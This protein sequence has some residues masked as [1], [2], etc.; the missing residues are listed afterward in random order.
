LHWRQ[1]FNY[2]RCLLWCYVP[3]QPFS[4]VSYQTTS[5][6]IAPFGAAT[7]QKYLFYFFYDLNISGG[8]FN[9]CEEAVSKSSCKRGL[10]AFGMII[11]QLGK[12]DR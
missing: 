4:P 6:L 2:F 3:R 5:R 10:F 1:A 7:G 11:A 12:G 8:S 9:S